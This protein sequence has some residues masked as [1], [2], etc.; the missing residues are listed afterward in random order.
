MDQAVGIPGTRIRLGAD[1][2]VGLIP[3]VGDV[4][5]GAVSGWFI[6][7]GAR[8]GAPP[9]V[10]A[11]M[12]LNVGID[13]LVGVVPLLGDLFDIGWKANLR[14]LALL[15]AHLA[16]PRGTRRR[17]TWALA[18]I[19][20]LV[21]AAIGSLVGAFAWLGVQLVEWILGAIRGP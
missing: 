7:S 17:S 1:A 9:A 8:L 19:A 20:L 14:N 15:E 5:G 11:R 18:G 13:A 6:V 2:L 10:L 4:V 3:G 21:I 12:A 16:D